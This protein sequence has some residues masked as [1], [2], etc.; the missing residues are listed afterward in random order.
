MYKYVLATTLIVGCTLPAF[1]EKGFYIVRGPH[2]KCTV[3]E[4]APSATET[5]A[6][7]PTRIWHWFASS[8]STNRASTRASASVGALFAATPSGDRVLA[9]PSSERFG[10]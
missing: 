5:T 7:R 10:N 4:T 3:V 2:K 6:K 9:S 1:A 8:A